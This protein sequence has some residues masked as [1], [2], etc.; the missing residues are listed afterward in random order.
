MTELA[1]TE[2]IAGKQPEVDPVLGV[3]EEK[4]PPKPI[5]L[6][7]KIREKYFSETD[8]KEIEGKDRRY[9]GRY[10]L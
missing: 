10:C 8:V 9:D 1:I 7:E 2:A 3:I 4:V 5:K 6:S